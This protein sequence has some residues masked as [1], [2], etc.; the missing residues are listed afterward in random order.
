MATVTN[1][2]LNLNTQGVPY[3]NGTGTF[4]GLDGSTSG[5]VLTSNG[6]GAAPSFQAA[7]GGVWTLIQSQTA[8][9][10]ASV[11]FTSGLTSSYKLFKLYI[12]GLQCVISGGSYVKILCSTNGGSTYDT[13][14]NYSF[15]TQYYGS[16]ASND[17]TRATSAN[18]LKWLHN[19]VPSSLTS[20][21]TGSSE[22]LITGLSSSAQY[23]QFR[24]I[25][26]TNIGSIMFEF[27][28][29]GSY[30]VATAVNAFRISHST[31]NIFLGTFSL[32]G[33]T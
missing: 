27:N 11:D 16:D 14:A 13:G 12:T 17:W 8:S 33:L 21:D 6:T 23:K 4:T 1:N 22:I 3:Y 18:D 24:C 10:Q 25:S 20:T 9:N 2:A 5:K 29:G 26:S 7:S 19:A 31:G 32:Y 15:N 30:N 28:S